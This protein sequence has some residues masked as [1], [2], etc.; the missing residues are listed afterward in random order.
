MT[1]QA[2]Y[3][4]E[5]RDCPRSREWK[6]GALRGLKVAFKEFKCEAH[7]YVSGT[8]QDDA[9]LAGIQAGLRE[10]RYLRERG[11]A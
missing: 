8:A 9:W 6:A 2:I 11:Q 10:G 5:F 4:A 1:A 3:D 7:P